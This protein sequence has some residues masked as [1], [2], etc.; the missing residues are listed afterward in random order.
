HRIEVFRFQ[1]KPHSIT[2]DVLP[3]FCKADVHDIN[4]VDVKTG[5]FEMWFHIFYLTNVL[6]LPPVHQYPGDNDAK[7]HRAQTDVKICK[8]KGDCSHNR[9]KNHQIISAFK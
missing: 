5:T 9:S 8:N 6:N 1:N 3:P 4:I 7:N 2:K